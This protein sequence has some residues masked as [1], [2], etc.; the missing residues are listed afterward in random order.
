VDATETGCAERLYLFGGVTDSATETDTYEV[1]DPATW[2]GATFTASGMGAQASRRETALFVANNE[3]AIAANLGACEYYLYVG[4][5]AS[6]PQDSPDDA[7][8]LWVA[9]YT[10]AADGELDAFTDAIEAG[11]QPTRFGYAAFWSREKFYT[12]GGIS[13]GAAEDTVLDGNWSNEPLIQNMNNASYPLVQPRYLFGFARHGS[14]A[15]LAGGEDDQG[16]A[17]ATTE[18]NV[19]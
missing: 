4:P 5:G 14:F 13:N 10:G 16:A 8:N 11:S 6:G 17:T 12:M 9:T 18:Y 3:N 7:E 2:A 1:L 15:Y 19:R